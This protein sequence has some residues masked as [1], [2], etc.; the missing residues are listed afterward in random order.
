MVARGYPSARNGV[1]MVWQ[2]SGRVMGI[3]T[4]RFPATLF[5]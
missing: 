1:D 4:V 2:G 3:T 5:R